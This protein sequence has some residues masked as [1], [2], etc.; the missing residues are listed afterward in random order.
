MA[1][2]AAASLLSGAGCLVFIELECCVMVAEKSLLCSSDQAGVEP[3]GPC[4][5]LTVSP[6]GVCLWLTVFQ[7]GLGT[8]PGLFGVGWVF[9]GCSIK[10]EEEQPIAWKRQSVS[11]ASLGSHLFGTLDQPQPCFAC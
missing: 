11:T 3:C 7:S 10:P 5:E 2:F 8:E 1:L 6:K 4:S 9:R